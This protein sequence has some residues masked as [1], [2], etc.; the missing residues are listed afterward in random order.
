MGILEKI[1]DMFRSGQTADSDASTVHD[2]NSGAADL[3]EEEKERLRFAAQY[4][5]KKYDRIIERLANE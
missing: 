1:K 3:G 2:G 4:T 5:V